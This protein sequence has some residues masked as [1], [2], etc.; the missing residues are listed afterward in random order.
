[1]NVF[2]RATL[3]FLLAPACLGQVK[4][5]VLHPL[6]GDMVGQLGGEEVE[7]VN[8]LG[9]DGDPHKFEPGAKELR[10]AQGAKLYFVSGKG[11]E[12][13]LPKLRNTV[14]AEKVVEVGKTL[15][16]LQ[17]TEICDHGDFVHEHEV[18][19]PHWWHSIDCWRRAAVVIRKELSRIDPDNS[20][21]YEARTRKV[22]KELADLKRWA[23]TE[24]NKVPKQHRTLA[25]AHAAFAYFCHEHKWKTLAVQGLNRERVESPK[26]LAEAVAAMR[27]EKVLAVFP[28]KRSN[29]KMLK[30]LAEE[31]GVTI[32]SP[33]QADG[34]ESIEKMIRH[35]VNTI[36]EALG[37]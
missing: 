28:E 7:V 36:V 13:Y 20:A 31:V 14:G 5:A 11:L 26:F 25:T 35:N 27:K 8:L 18:E 15:P 16:T 3:V 24:L 17:A 32:G 23:A 6:L 10:A 30:S 37:E 9:P 21:L 1:M 12:P 22:R 2:L 29:P 33:L 4:V 34:G 19:D